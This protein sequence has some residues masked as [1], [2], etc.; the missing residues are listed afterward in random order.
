M[1]DHIDFWQKTS[2]F[3]VQTKPYQEN[4]AAARVAKLDLQVFL[5]RIREERSVCS[6]VRMV[7]KALFP[8]YFFTRL[9]PLV[10]IDAV[11][12]T[13]GVL[14]VVSSGRFPIPVDDEVVCELQDRAKEDG[15]IKIR[16]QGLKPGDRVSILDGP[17]EGLIG[18]VLREMD[19]RKRVAILLETLLRARVLIERRWLEAEAA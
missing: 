13:P 17:L 11:R 14:R 3:A 9:C 1:S 10:S 19:D 6:V 2:W 15:L 4:M 8:G 7:T 18:T 5:P 16:P 12:Y